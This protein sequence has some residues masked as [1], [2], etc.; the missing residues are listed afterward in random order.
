MGPLRCLYRS[1]FGA[2]QH[3]EGADMALVKD[4]WR[5]DA[6]THLRGLAQR[7]KGRIRQLEDALADAR[8]QLYSA[9]GE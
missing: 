6:E 8:R 4:D 9:V 3:Y 5:G 2:D 1:I 7:N